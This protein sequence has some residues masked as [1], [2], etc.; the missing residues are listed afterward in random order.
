MTYRTNISIFLRGGPPSP[1][2]DA[3]RILVAI[4]LALKDMGCTSGTSGH[5]I[6]AMLSQAASRHP[7]LAS[8]LN[9]HQAKLHSDLI[10]ITCNDK[11]NQPVF[12]K[13][14]NYPHARYTRFV[15]DWGGVS[16]TS[17]QSIAAFAQTCN[18]L[19]S[20]LQTHK[21]TLGIQI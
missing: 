20:H 16:E 18:S 17:H 13:A 10:Q 1:L 14:N 19:L 6:P 11:N 2:L 5:D 21:A 15:G 12:V 3:Y 9:G 4:E 7:M 8:Q